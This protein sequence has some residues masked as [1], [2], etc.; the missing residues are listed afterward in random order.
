M[1]ESPLATGRYGRRQLLICP[2]GGSVQV[3]AFWR[4]EKA[5][6]DLKNYKPMSAILAVLFSPSKH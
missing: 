6:E 4:G 1:P 3:P 2:V 5:F